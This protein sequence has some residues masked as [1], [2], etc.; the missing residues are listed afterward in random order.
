MA[1]DSLTGPIAAFI[2]FYNEAILKSSSY[3]AWRGISSSPSTV[4]LDISAE[5]LRRGTK[6]VDDVLR[7]QPGIEYEQEIFVTSMTYESDAVARELGIV[8]QLPCVVFFDSPTTDK[9]YIIP[10]GD[11]MDRAYEDIRTLLTSFSQDPSNAIYFD[12]LYRWHALKSKQERLEAQV[13]HVRAQHYA[14]DS[15]AR[16]ENKIRPVLEEAR[17][18]LS[19][20]RSKKFRVTLNSLSN[21]H[22]LPWVELREAADRVRQILYMAHNSSPRETNHL[23]NLAKIEVDQVMRSVYDFFEIYQVEESPW[24]ANQ[25]AANQIGAYLSALT[26]ELSGM[27]RPSLEP[28]FRRLRSRRKRATWLTKARASVS[29]AMQQ[30]PSVLETIERAST[31]LRG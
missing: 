22:L 18:Q 9:F 25:E 10:L 6:A 26:G 16:R 7:F 17:E 13:S 4:R 21:S 15:V 5:V 29:G 23:I 24:A 28:H 1:L 11:Q 3:P 12:K 31:T 2:L 30:A 8:D 27:P 19:T 14:R 20:G